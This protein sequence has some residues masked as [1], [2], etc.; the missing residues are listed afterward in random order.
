MGEKEL[1]ESLLCGALVHEAAAH[2]A[3]FVDKEKHEEAIREAGTT[4]EPVN[5]VTANRKR[6]E[7]KEDAFVLVE[8]KS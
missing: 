3:G 1:S 7:E 8:E 2:Q 4:D 5:V 6:N